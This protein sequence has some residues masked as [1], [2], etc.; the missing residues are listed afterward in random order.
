MPCRM[1]AIL[2]LSWC[3]CFVYASQLSMRK[4]DGLVFTEEVNMDRLEKHIFACKLDLDGGR[5]GGAQLENMLAERLMH[6]S[7]LLMRTLRSY[8]VP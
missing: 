3:A 6:E 7:A 1:R 8:A 2:L 4:V 5:G